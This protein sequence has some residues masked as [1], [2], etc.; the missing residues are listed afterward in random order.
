LKDSQFRSKY[1]CQPILSYGLECYG[2]YPI[3]LNDQKSLDFVVIMLIN[4][5]S[6]ILE[7]KRSTSAKRKI[8]MGYFVTLV[9]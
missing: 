7:T 6:E 3:N 1:K 4:K 8:V 9:Y 2:C 5:C